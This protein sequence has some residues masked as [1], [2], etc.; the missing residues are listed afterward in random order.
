[1]GQN[2]YHYYYYFIAVVIGEVLLYRACLHCTGS[3]C[4]FPVIFSDG[5]DVAYLSANIQNFSEITS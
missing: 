1:M 3:I 5:K 4:M 2:G